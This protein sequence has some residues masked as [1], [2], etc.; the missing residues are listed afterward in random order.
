MD[1]IRRPI[2]YGVIFFF[3]MKHGVFITVQVFRQ[4]LVYGLIFG[5]VLGIAIIW[6]FRKLF[7]RADRQ[8]RL[9]PLEYIQRP[10]TRNWPWT[11]INHQNCVP[12]EEEAPPSP[13]HVGLNDDRPHSEK[14]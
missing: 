3:A 2:F 9:H 6:L 7:A 13:W 14:R 12:P 5:A 8:E 10:V 1:P 4:H 11:K